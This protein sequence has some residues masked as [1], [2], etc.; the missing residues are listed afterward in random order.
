MK[1]ISMENNLNEALE[2]LLEAL[3]IINR[4]LTRANELLADSAKALEGY[5]ESHD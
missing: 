1:Y 5:I 4:D 2:M 3:K